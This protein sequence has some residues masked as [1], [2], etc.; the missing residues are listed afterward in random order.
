MRSTFEM[1]FKASGFRF[2]GNRQSPNIQPKTVNRKPANSLRGFTLIELVM[3]ILIAAIIAV[4]AIP[5][6][7]DVDVFNSRGFSDQVQASLR[8][9]QKVAIAQ[10]RFVCVSFASNNITLTIGATTA[11]GTALAFPSG[12]ETYS[13]TAPS[14][15][16]F[17]A[18]PNDFYFDALGK[19]S[20]AP[21]TINIIGAPN[22]ITIEA[23]TGYVH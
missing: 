16:V 13:I 12:G 1:Q 10:H 5:R 8:Y 18:T 23:E 17:S 11:C 4:V 22:S 2:N 7:F 19:P 3:V 14:D 6:F 20:Y 15:I 21:Q 9:A